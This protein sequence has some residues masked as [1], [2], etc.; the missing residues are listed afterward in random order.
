MAT[1]SETRDARIEELRKREE[2]IFDQRDGYE[3]KIS[4]IIGSELSSSQL[5]QLKQLFADI[6]RC[7][8]GIA[9]IQERMD[10][11]AQAI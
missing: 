8:E 1:Y 3:R 2:K 6:E 5:L 7:E 9:R 10:D 4:E 11:I